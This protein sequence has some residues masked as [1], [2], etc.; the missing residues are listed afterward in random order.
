MKTFPHIFVLIFT[1]YLNSQMISTDKTKVKLSEQKYTR[2]PRTVT[3]NGRLTT[4][5]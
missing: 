4:E 5:Q 1:N 3:H 2:K